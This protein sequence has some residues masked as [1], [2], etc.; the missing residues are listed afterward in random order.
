MLVKW[1]RMVATMCPERAT[2]TFPVASCAETP[3]ATHRRSKNSTTVQFKLFLILLLSRKQN[4]KNLAVDETI[5]KCK[6]KMKIVVVLDVRTSFDNSILFAFAAT[7]FWSQIVLFLASTLSL[8]QEAKSPSLILREYV[9]R[10]CN[11]KP[12][13][14]AADGGWSWPSCVLNRNKKLLEA[15]VTTQPI[16][17]LLERNYLV[18]VNSTRVLFVC[19]SLVSTVFVFVWTPSY[20][21]HEIIRAQTG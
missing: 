20:G 17:S 11:T 4:R 8:E 21:S 13:R 6:Y 16:M 3:I 15:V 12:I 5:A 10:K 7:R 19:G 18:C 14:V 1:V 9:N 2:K